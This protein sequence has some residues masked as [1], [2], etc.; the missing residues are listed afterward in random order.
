MEDPAIRK[1]LMILCAFAALVS[2]TKMQPV[3]PVEPTGAGGS[4]LQIRF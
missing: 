1:T 2:C 4:R 3:E